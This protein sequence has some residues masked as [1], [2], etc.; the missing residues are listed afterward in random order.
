[1]TEYRRYSSFV[2]Q[3]SGTWPKVPVPEDIRRINIISAFLDM[4]SF[5]YCKFE[6]IIALIIEKK[7]PD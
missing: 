2:R 7:A 4:V 1:M 3:I 5:I 6:K